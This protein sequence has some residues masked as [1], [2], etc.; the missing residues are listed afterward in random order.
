MVTY[1]E[2]FALENES[3][4]PNGRPTLGAAFE[5]FRAQWESGERDRELALHLMFLAWYLYLE[6]SHLTGLD[7]ARNPVGG[8]AAVFNAAH[9]WLLPT[10]AD[11]EDVEALYV[12]GLAA[13]LCPWALGEASLWTARSEAYRARYRQLVPDGISPAVFQGRGAYGDYFAGQARVA[14]GY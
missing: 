4:G 2:G 7:E 14:G 3:L 8:L 11:T 9:D 13:R 5:V 1:A 6:P 12:V 10:G